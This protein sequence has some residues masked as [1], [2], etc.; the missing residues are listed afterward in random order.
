[1]VAMNIPAL[2]GEVK[3]SEL[4]SKSFEEKL[5]FHIYIFKWKIQTHFKLYKAGIW[6]LRM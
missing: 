1:M 6:V 3:L 5:D 2:Y 4:R